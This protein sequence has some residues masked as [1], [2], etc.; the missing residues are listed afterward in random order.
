MVPLEHLLRAPDVE[1][2]VRR[3]R[4]GEVRDDLQVRPHD[5]GLGR[6]ARDALQAPQLAVHLAPRLLRQLERLDPLA[7]IVRLLRVD[8]LA[9]LLLD[10]LHLLSEEDL[11]L[12]IT[13]LLLDLLANLLLRLEQAD[14]LL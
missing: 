8:I 3:F 2:F 10:R 1:L 14:L 12:P 11:A 6:F 9:Q 5:L 4:P 13:Q 7:E